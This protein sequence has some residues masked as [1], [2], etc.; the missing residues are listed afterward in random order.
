MKLT[1]RLARLLR[2]DVHTLL[3]ELED[4]AAILRQALREMEAIIESNETMLA[5]LSDRKVRL[6]DYADRQREALAPLKEQL[7]VCLSAGNDAL[8]R[9]V[10]KRRLQIE[11]HLRVC[12]ENA[13]GLDRRREA[14]EQELTRQRSSLADLRQQA[15]QVIK[16][17]PGVTGCATA[18]AHPDGGISAAEVEVV[19]LAEKQRCATVSER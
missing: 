2:A 12:A 14:L 9:T 1:T 6:H 19:L 5:E 15:G 8:A 17:E 7:Q 13:T 10:I 16:S 18:A 11:Q 4:P 3:D